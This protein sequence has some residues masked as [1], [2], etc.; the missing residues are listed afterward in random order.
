MATIFRLHQSNFRSGRADVFCKKSVLRS[1]TKF[2][3]KH[4]CQSLFFN[5][6]AGLRPA[7]LLKKRLWHR[8]FP[9][10]FLKFLRTLF[11][12]E[13]L[14]WL[15]LQLLSQLSTHWVGWKKDKYIV[16]HKSALSFT[17]HKLSLL[18]LLGRGTEFLLLYW[19]NYVSGKCGSKSN[20]VSFE[21][22]RKL[23]FFL[24]FFH[25]WCHS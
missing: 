14:W 20:L 25:V 7:T 10:N 22:I 19:M 23:I 11:F 6:V 16:A 9:V 18:S 3:G 8:C 5:N 2:T 24:P 15:L 17:F 21:S 12:T 1:S 4:L 13:H